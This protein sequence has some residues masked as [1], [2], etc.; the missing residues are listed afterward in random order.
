M[1][2]CGFDIPKRVLG[3]VGQVDFKEVAQAASGLR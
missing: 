2:G 3:V 1:D